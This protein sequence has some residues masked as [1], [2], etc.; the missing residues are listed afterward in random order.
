[1]GRTR[2]GKWDGRMKNGNTKSE[3]SRWD[4]MGRACMAVLVVG[5]SCYWVL[6]RGGGSVPGR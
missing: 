3:W 4:I 1:M 6:S 5:G 2:K